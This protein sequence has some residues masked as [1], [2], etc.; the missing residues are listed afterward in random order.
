MCPSL[1]AVAAAV[2]LTA[3][4]LASQI[5]KI[6]NARGLFLHLSSLLIGTNI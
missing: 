3:V 4:N 2:S 1:F 6:E 5:S